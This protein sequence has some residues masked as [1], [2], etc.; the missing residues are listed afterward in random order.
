MRRLP[1]EERVGN[2]DENNLLLAQSSERLSSEA[3]TLRRQ[4]VTNISDHENSGLV[5]NS[6]EAPVRSPLALNLVKIGGKIA[7]QTDTVNRCW[8][9]VANVLDEL[10]TRKTWGVPAFSSASKYLDSDIRFKRLEDAAH[11]GHLPLVSMQAGDIFA[12]PWT[13]YGESLHHGRKDGHVAVYLGPGALVDRQSKPWSEGSHGKPRFVPEDEFSAFPL[14][15]NFIAKPVE[16]SD[17]LAYVTTKAGY[18]DYS[19]VRIWR[20]K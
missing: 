12:L 13:A 16:A 14:L 1:I 8:Y 17:H 7:S 11:S 10:S 4:A 6:N 19:R 2:F 9:A 15:N 5:T 18:Y 20:A 3:Q